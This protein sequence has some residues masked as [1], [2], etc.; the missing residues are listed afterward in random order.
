MGRASEQG[1]ARPA[2]SF[3]RFSWCRSKRPKLSTILGKF[4]NYGVKNTNLLRKLVRKLN[5]FDAK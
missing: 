5:Y 4:Y 3:A 1:F 2:V